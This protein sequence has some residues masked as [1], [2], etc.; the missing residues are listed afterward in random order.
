[1]MALDAENNLDK[2]PLKNI[3][4]FV[5][6]CQARGV[7]EV[8]VTGTNTDPLL[9]QHTDKLISYLRG[10]IDGLVLGVR[11]NAAAHHSKLHFYDKASITVCSFDPI[12]YKTMMGRGD[13]PGIE[14]LMEQLPHL[15]TTLKVNVVLGPEN[16]GTG[17]LEKTLWRLGT[18]GVKRVNLREPYG[19]PTIGDPMSR[20]GLKRNET[21]LGMPVYLW[22]T[23]EVTYWD[24][25]YVEVE[26]VN[27]YA[28]GNISEDY[29]ITRGH[30]PISGSVLSQSNFA[31]GRSRD[32]WINLRKKT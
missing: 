7:K 6:F 20:I 1:M 17:D 29:P 15:A 32:Q 13:P 23:M 28:N 8:N 21:R 4:A 27:L 14:W 26:S 2:W 12:V 30:D 10:R 9:Y 19:Q 22:G 3:D 11:T 24:V 16:V 31:H 25:H 5:G 18:A